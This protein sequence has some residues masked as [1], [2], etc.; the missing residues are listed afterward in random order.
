[1]HFVL[2]NHQGAAGRQQIIKNGI[3]GVETRG[4]GTIVGGPCRGLLSVMPVGG[5]CRGLLS[6]MPIGGFCQLWLPAVLVSYAFWRP[7]PEALVS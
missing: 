2:R 6:V 1:M 3:T 5:P 7:L 4:A